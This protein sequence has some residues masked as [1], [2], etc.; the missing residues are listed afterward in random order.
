MRE[1]N[2]E[3]IRCS[4]FLVNVPVPIA[5]GRFMPTVLLGMHTMNP[6]MVMLDGMFLQ[7]RVE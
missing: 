7:E 5:P 2:D 1:P 4:P 6:T 3:D